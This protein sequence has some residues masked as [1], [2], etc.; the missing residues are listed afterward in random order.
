MKYFHYISEL[1]KQILEE[2]SANILQAAQIVANQIAQ[3]KIVYIYGPGGHS[4]I[5]AQEIFFRAGG[6]MHISAI[7]DEGTLLSSGA[8]RSMAIERI[9]GYAPI[10]L[11]DYKLQAGDLLII[12]NAYGINAAT[13]DSALFARENGITSIGISSIS[14]AQMTSSDHPARHV[15]KQN[16]HDLT[17][18]H[19]DSK[20]LPGDAVIE[21]EGMNQKVGAVSTFAN[22][23]ILNSLII[24][25]VD[26]LK[27]KG[28][29][30][31]IWKSGNAHGG[32]EWN[33]QFI[34]KFKEVVKKL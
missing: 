17:D 26:I 27:Q 15:T 11:E 14:H 5:A 25:T 3:N 8:L 16:L 9:T 12:V 19:I 13:I 1:L 33:N 20:I 22:A 4:N 18:Y 10:V 29:E 34:E 21:I 6:L 30:P 7:L 23:I 28:I 31:P 2:E 32:D 24:E